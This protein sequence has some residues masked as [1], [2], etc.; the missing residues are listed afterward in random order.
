[1]AK[2]KMIDFSGTGSDPYTIADMTDAYKQNGAQR[3]R[4]GVK[5]IDRTTLLVQDEFVLENPSE[6]WWFMHTQ[7][8]ITVAPDGQTAMFSQNGKQMEARMIDAP[9]GSK[10]V[11]MP[12]ER[13]PESPGP[14]EG[15]L[16]AEGYRKLAIR[17]VG[18][19]DVSLAVA[20]VPQ[21]GQA[22]QVSRTRSL[23]EW[24]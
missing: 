3:V 6:V 7:A 23:S 17:M 1:M 15:E 19:T 14:T 22:V 10:F 2:G 4:R 12:A 5:L 20:L 11:V 9:E 24:K 13:L 21:G 8:E 16:G 18:V